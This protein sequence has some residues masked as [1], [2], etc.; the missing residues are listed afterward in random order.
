MSKRK[1]TV[2]ERLERWHAEDRANAEQIR[3]RDERVAKKFA[4]VLVSLAC[5]ERD[6]LRQ[7]AS[8]HHLIAQL[9]DVVRDVLRSLVD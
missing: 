7:D 1:E 6:A 9:T 8:A 5:I 3:E 2:D 4:D